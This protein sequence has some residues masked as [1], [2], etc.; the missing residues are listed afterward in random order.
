LNRL[1]CLIDIGLLSWL[2]TAGYVLLLFLLYQPTLAYLLVKWNQ[3]D[4]NYCYLIPCIVLYLIWEKRATLAATP[5]V[6]SWRGLAPLVLGLVCY[7]LGDLGG[8]YTMLFLSLWLVAVALVWMHLG[9]TKLR[10]ISFPLLFSLAMFVPPD[11]VYVPLSFRLKLVSSQLGV[12]LL[13]LWGMSAYREGNIIDLGFTRLQVV[14]A[15]SGLRYLVPLF[16][17][18][19][20]MTC[21]APMA[22]WKRVLLVASSVPLSLFT[23]SLRIASVGLLFQYLG[24]MVARGFFHDFSGW[25]IFM[26]SLGFLMLE[27]WLLNRVFPEKPGAAGGKPGSGSRGPGV[28]ARQAPQGEDRLPP[29]GSGWRAALL[30]PPPCAAA[31]LVLA[32]TLALARAVPWREKIPLARQF[33][34]FP[35]RLGAWNGT[36]NL[37]EPAAL[38]TLRLSDYLLVDYH[39]PA[40]RQVNLYVAYYASQL[41]GESIHSPATCLPGGGWDFEESDAIKLTGA[42]SAARAMTVRRAFMSKSGERMLVYYWFPQRGRIL[43]EAPQ[44]KFYAFWDAITR[45]RTDGALVRVITPLAGGEEPASAEA[46]LRGFCRAALPVLEGYLPK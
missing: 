42:G 37:M 28:G 10:G 26:A 23:N 36:R 7:W 38:D 32:A 44:L 5:S 43:T 14:D 3:D 22:P 18:G 12:Y 35:L 45:R 31:F 29:T 21:R 8:E 39:D 41:K 33:S 1:A 6:P 19:V 30:H 34:S 17:M 9:W 11:A 20:L 46:R 16:V 25:I 13:Q 24:A 2:R 4:F 27:V 40:G 15:C